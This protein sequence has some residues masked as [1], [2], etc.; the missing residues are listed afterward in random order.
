MRQVNM[1]NF[2]A[3]AKAGT[4]VDLPATAGTQVDLPATAGTQVD[5]PKHCAEP[6]P[7]FAVKKV[8]RDWTLA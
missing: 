1:L 5:L 2:P 6:G 7:R 3:P 8:N 4:Q